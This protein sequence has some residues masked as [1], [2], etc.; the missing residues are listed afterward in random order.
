MKTIQKIKTYNA[1]P[2]AVFNC[3]DDLGVTGMHMTKSSMPMMG[4]KMKLQ[5]LTPHKTA[6]NTKYRWTGKVLWWKLDFTVKVTEWQRG[7][8]K[9][10]Q[11][12][13]PVKLIIYSW[14]QMKLKIWT[15]ENES[16]AQ[17]SISYERPKGLFNRLLCSLVGDWYC[18]WCLK[19]M[20]NNTEKKLSFSA[21]QQRPLI[22]TQPKIM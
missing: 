14:F 17:L 12:I 2:E 13:G 18:R 15:Y 19:N 4:G 10:W 7:K 21:A 1:S 9:I 8:L 20:L 5:F 16:L 6:L 22:I 11:T 3:L